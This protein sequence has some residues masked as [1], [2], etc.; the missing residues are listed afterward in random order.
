MNKLKIAYDTAGMLLL[1]GERKFIIGSYHLPK[2]E[3]PYQELRE[4]GFNFLRVSANEQA[5][6]EAHKNNLRTWISIGYADPAKFQ[7]SS[8]K[9]IEKIRQFK[10]HPALLCWEMVDEPAYTW[11]SNKLRVAPETLIESYKLI[12]QEDKD[13]LI[14]TNHAPVNLVS[15]LQK[16]NPATDIVACDIYPVIP[17]GIRPSYALFDDGL[18]GDLLNTYISQIGEFTDRMRK[19]AGQ[20]KPVFMVLQGFAWELLRDKK[21]QDPTMV[22]FPTYEESRFMAYNAIIH[23]ATGIIYWGT[24]YTPQ[25]SMFWNDLKKVTRELGDLQDVLAAK[26]VKLNIQLDYVEMGHSVDAGIEMLAKEHDGKIFLLTA[27]ADKN[28]AKVTFSG[29]DNF[30]QATVCFENRNLN[31]KNGTITERYEPFDIHIFKLSSGVE[32]AQ[33]KRN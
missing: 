16:Y 25:P 7:E 32:V 1:D 8:Q 24:T 12:E 33:K 21:D 9:L 30:V 10:N 26:S 22:K 15:T 19:I 28:P 18:Q 17:H 14:Y 13:H 2:G 6:D 5:L 4:A 29:L 27:N 23:G 20:G 31:I 3:S 11:K